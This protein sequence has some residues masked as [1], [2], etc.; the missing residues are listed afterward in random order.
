[1]A[2][3]NAERVAGFPSGRLFLDSIQQALAVALVNNYAFRRPSPRIYRGRLTPS[4][5]P[6]FSLNTT[7]EE[8]GGRFL[9]ANY[10]IDPEKKESEIT[11]AD[12]FLDR[13]KSDLAP[14]TAARLSA[15]FPYVSLMPRLEPPAPNFHFGDGGYFDNDGT[16]SAIEFLWYAL[17][18]RNT[19]DPPVPVLILEIRDGPRSERGRRPRPAGKE[20]G[21]RRT[22]YRPAIDFL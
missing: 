11:P 17:K 7:A 6:A 20:M 16:A 3:V 5:M 1:M 19:Q 2:A 22:G 14:S 4:T 18:S 15:N 21:A 10:R 12:S 13:L 9:I 8:T